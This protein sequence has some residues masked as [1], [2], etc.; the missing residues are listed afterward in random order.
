[1]TVVVSGADAIGY[2]DSQRR[3]RLPGITPSRMLTC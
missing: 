2:P 3:L 1:M